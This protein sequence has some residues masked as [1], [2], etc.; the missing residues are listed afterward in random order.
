MERFGAEEV[1]ESQENAMK[2]LNRRKQKMLLKKGGKRT[3]VVGDGE[4]RKDK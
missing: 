4:R 3:I 2:H 1:Q